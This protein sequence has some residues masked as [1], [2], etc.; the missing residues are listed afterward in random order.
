MSMKPKV[1]E[2]LRAALAK[3]P[4]E[5]R[6]LGQPDCAFVLEAKIRRA[7]AAVARLVA[8][9]GKAEAEAYLNAKLEERGWGE[10]V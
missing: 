2:R 7:D 6:E 4:D 10:R 5:L 9:M 1:F 8:K 3:G